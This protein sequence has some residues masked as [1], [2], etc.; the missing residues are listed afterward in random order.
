M[1]P[2]TVPHPTQAAI[3][4]LPSQRPWFTGD[5]KTPFHISFKAQLPEF[6]YP[7][8]VGFSCL[9]IYPEHSGLARA[10]SDAELPLCT[11]SQLNRHAE[12]YV[13][14]SQSNQPE[15]ASHTKLGNARNKGCPAKLHSAL[16]CFL[17]KIWRRSSKKPQTKQVSSVSIYLPGNHPPSF[18]TSYFYS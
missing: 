4:P 18:C 17:C 10:D 13:D 2:V 5:D 6:I 9:P 14:K 3:A 11:Q 1:H 16:S 12:K 7:R 8:S 15:Q